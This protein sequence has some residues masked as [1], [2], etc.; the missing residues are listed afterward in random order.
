M[1][2][3]Y[4][5]AGLANVKVIHPLDTEDGDDV[6]PGVYALKGGATIQSTAKFGNALL[7]DAN[8]Q[9]LDSDVAVA[10]FDQS[11][12]AKIMY[13]FW[14]RTPNLAIQAGQVEFLN[15]AGSLVKTRIFWDAGIR[16]RIEWVRS[17][18]LSPGKPTICMRSTTGK[19]SVDVFASVSAYINASGTS[20]GKIFKDGVDIT[21][22]IVEE[23][24]PTRGTSGFD[25][26]RIGNHTNG[27]DP[28][29]LVDDVTVL[30]FPGLSD[31]KAT[32]LATNY[33]DTQRFG[34]RPK[35]ESLAAA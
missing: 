8:F 27:L 13:H 22:S 17:V 28:A 11:D 35:F 23:A 16:M 1:A 34:H 10:G 33:H 14:W 9:R 31:A 26:I 4:S 6:G 30:Q 29:R 15:S 21:A 3:F 18:D 25:F 2:G 24:T 5:G 20:E 19:F 32:S 7:C 12:T